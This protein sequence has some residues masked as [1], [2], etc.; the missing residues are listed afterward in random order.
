MGERENSRNAKNSKREY[1]RIVRGEEGRCKRDLTRHL[2]LG[3]NAEK[4]QLP[5]IRRAATMPEEQPLQALAPL[6]IIGEPKQFI[7]V[8]DVDEVKQ[9]GGCFHDGEGWRSRIIDEDGDSAFFNINGGMASLMGAQ[10][11]TSIEQMERGYGGA[12]RGQGRGARV[13]TIRVQPQE[14]IAFLDVGPDIDQCRAPRGI[15]D[16][17][18]LFEQ[19]LHF[20][21]IGRALR[22]E[23]EPLFLGHL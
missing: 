6:Q 3:E 15:V 9:F 1:G 23:M 2:L 4:V 18:E 8:R 5:L 21:A 22:D 16:V 14:P 7:S 20:L 11:S 17:M 13:G 19:D 12:G 10:R